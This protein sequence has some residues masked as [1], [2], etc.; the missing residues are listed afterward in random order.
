ME[1]LIARIAASAG[2]EPDVAQQ[3]V[4]AILAFLRKEGPKAEIDEL[5]AAIPGAAEEAAAA[6]N[7]GGSPSGLMSKM[8]GGL[9]GL[10]ARLSGLGLSMSQMHAIGHELFAYVRDRTGD[11][12]LRRVA[13]AIPGLNQLL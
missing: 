5:F 9:M 4:G 13:S 10:A 11:E 2:I 1:D 7:A 3:A 6:E 8:G 12:R